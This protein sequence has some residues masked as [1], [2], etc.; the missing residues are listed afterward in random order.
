MT[1]PAHAFVNNLRILHAIDLFEL[2]DAGIFSEDLKQG[3]LEWK[4]WVAF[5]D[6]PFRT[7]MAWDEKKQAAL[8]GIIKA[9]GGG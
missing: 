7:I 1:N 4:K 3:M 2:Q 8:W 6:D 9:R 5:R